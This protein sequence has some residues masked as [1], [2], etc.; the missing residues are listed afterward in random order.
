MIAATNESVDVLR[1]TLLSGTNLAEN[2]RT[3]VSAY[4][5]WPVLTNSVK[6]SAVTTAASLVV[7]SVA[8]YGVEV[9]HDK[10][11]DSVFKVLMLT[12]MVPFTATM[13]PTYAAGM[14][15]TFMNA[16]NNFMWA[17]LIMS[18]DSTQTFPMLISNMTSGHYT[19]YGELMLAVLISTLPTVVVFFAL[20]KSF[21]QE[22]TGTVK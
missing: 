18:N 10:G 21:V 19:D 4:N 16:W 11:K 17:K 14:T 20:Q 8:G 12:M 6:Y 2:W 22:M 3:L 1:G 5:I 9:Y 7:S 15:I 13:K